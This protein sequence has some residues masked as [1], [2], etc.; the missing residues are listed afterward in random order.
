MAKKKAD[1]DKPVTL[2][3]VGR[4]V[5]FGV[6]CGSARPRRPKPWTF[7]RRLARRARR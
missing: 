3:D 7:A 1:A 2:S 6:I 5:A 4:H